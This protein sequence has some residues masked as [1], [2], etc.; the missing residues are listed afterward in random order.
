MADSDRV[1]TANVTPGGS[2]EQRVLIGGVLVVAIALTTVFVVLPFVRHWRARETEM[3]AAR[4]RVSSLQSYA[5]RAPQLEAAASAAE[6]LLANRSRRVLR[7]R[8]TTL[9]AS[10]L[11]TM[12]QDAADASHVV[13]TRL[14]VV[15]DASTASV[16]ATMSVYSD[17]VGV[18][19]LLDLLATGPRVVM[20]DKVVAQR[21]AALLGAADVVQMTLTLH[22]PVSARALPTN[23]GM[24]GEGVATPSFAQMPTRD[25]MIS[26]VIR[27]N[28]FSATRRA[29]M[30]AF[31][32]PGRD[33][34][35]G[36]SVPGVPSPGTNTI[37]V[38]E[39]PRLSGI[40]VV[41]GERRAL[42]Q[43]SDSDGVPRLY[44]VGDARAGF[45]VVSVGADFVVLSS[46][47]GSRT[48]RLSSHA[49]P[50]SLK[51]SPQ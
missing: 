20:V 39:L 44:R 36:T 50:D 38:S 49:A 12:L 16:P 17:I 30:V 4:A 10:A 37:D 7:A 15:P 43:L 34:V 13:V 45:R 1:S 18:A 14:D 19:T 48:L 11:Q 32:A 46:S 29:P 6:R 21:N 8:S 31:A 5:A 40:V 33:L 41:S 23:S 28:V 27:G 26:A 24:A 22:A 9:A 51:H 3:A 2:R 47:S 35:T 25:T 42:L